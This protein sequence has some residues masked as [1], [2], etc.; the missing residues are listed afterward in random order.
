MPFRI[1]RRSLLCSLP[2]LATLACGNRKAPSELRLALMP[3]L[4][5][6]G[7]FLAQELGLFA[8][9]G[10]KLKVEQLTRPEHVTALLAGGRIDIG[11]TSLNPAFINAVA[12]GARIR[13]VAG[14]NVLSPACGAIGTLYVNRK[15]FPHGLTD[16]RQL[17]GKRVSVPVPTSAAAFFLDTMLATGGLSSAQLNMVYLPD[18][19]AI[20]A[21]ESGR[22]DAMV[23]LL[24]QSPAAL[25]PEI[26]S[27]MRP[28]DIIP[29]HQWSFIVFG[30]TL[31]N[32]DLSA[33]TRFLA[34]CLEGARAFAAGQTP[35]F[36]SELARSQGLDPKRAWGGCRGAFS[37][38]GRIDEPSVRRYVDWVVR[39]GFSPRTLPIGSL[40]DTR[41]VDALRAGKGL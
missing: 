36:L 32:G 41:F 9:Y 21:L 26:L 18:A 8:K 7:F 14:R 39:R 28:V 5:Q 4:N 27:V 17:S 29:G 25:S 10:L 24:D 3:T 6:A 33:G 16:V 15:M 37:P 12:A 2:G 19:E 31:L 38:D 13:V 35:R 23:C 20:I 1:P 22:L 34:A 30:R 40:I 11:F